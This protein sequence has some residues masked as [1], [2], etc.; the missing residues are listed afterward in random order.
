MQAQARTRGRQ[1]L[2][3]VEVTLAALLLGGCQADDPA[4]TPTVP[5]ATES[6]HPSQSTTA[7]ETAEERARRL[8]GEAVVKYWASVDRLA[9][10]PTAPISD[11]AA[12]AAGQARTQQE[13]TLTV[14]RQKAW[15]QTG[16]ASVS[17]LRVSTLSP[18]RFSVSACVDVTRV[19]LVN[20]QGVSQ[21]NP[22]RP[23]LQRFS[24]TVGK[25]GNGFRVLEDNLK[26]TAC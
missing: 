22:N 5:R 11:L 2:A 15:K 13:S 3:V 23:D 17:G 25:Q 9:S 18:E 26:A 19:D 21:V 20:G 14:Y 10:Q 24:Y 1:L 8:A 7:P 12:V 6:P 4:P 16:L